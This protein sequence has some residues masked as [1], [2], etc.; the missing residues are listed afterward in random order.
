M[1]HVREEVPE[2]KDRQCDLLRGIVENSLRDGEKGRR[3]CVST[4][5]GARRPSSAN[6][7]TSVNNFEEARVFAETSL[8]GVGNF[9]VTGDVSRL[10]KPKH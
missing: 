4:S 9:S 7:S 1:S 8:M 3:A 2:F 10:Q 6:H 5:T